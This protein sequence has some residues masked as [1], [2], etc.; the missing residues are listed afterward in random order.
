MAFARFSSLADAGPDTEALS[1][2]TFSVT[3]HQLRH[4]ALCVAQR[5]LDVARHR[6]PGQS[7]A[8]SSADHLSLPVVVL[9]LPRGRDYC[10]AVLG[11]VA[12]GCVWCPVDVDWCVLRSPGP[13]RR[14]CDVPVICQL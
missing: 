2:P 8:T 9:A 10:A 4:A 1:G 5:L 13:C 14:R 7:G 3:R 11:T 6:G 12:A